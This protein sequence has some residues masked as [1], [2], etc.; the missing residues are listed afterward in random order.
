MN[1]QM[2]KFRQLPCR[3]NVAWQGDIIKMPSWITEDAPAPY[4]PVTALWADAVSGLVHN[5]DLLH[6]DK[7]T[8]DA[9]LQCL[10]DFACNKKTAG[11]RPGILEVRNE[12]LADYMRQRLSDFDIKVRVRTRLQWL[13]EAQASLY[14]FFKVPD[15]PSPFSVKGITLDMMR[16]FAEAGVEFWRAQPWQY[17]C[18]EDL[19]EIETPFVDSKT[20]FMTVMGQGGETFGLGF[21]ESRDQYDKI[22]TSVPGDDSLHFSAW[23]VLFDPIISI[24]VKDADIWMDH[25][26]PVADENGYPYAILFSAG[27]KLRRPGSDLLAF[28]EGLL[29]VLAQDREDQLDAGRWTAT[30]PTFQGEM[31]FTLALPDVLTYLEDP[32]AVQKG[33]NDKLFD[34]RLMEKSMAELHKIIKE[35][36]FDDIDEINAFL[37]NHMKSGKITLPEPQTP[38]EKAQDLVYRALQARGRIRVLLARKALEIYPDCA[39]AYVLL[40]ERTTDSLKAHDLYLEGMLAGERT[41]GP[42]T[43]SE[44]AGHFWGLLE[45]RPYMRARLGLAQTLENLDRMEEACEH[46]RELLRLNPNDNQGVREVFIPALL[47]LNTNETNNELEQLLNKYDEKH[48]AV[49][50]YTRALLSFRQKGDAPASR[51]HLKHAFKVNPHVAG[52]LLADEDEE[53]SDA[54]NGY[55]AGSPEEAAYCV[56]LLEDE[57]AATDGAMDWLEKY[58]PV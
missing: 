49:W 58:Y 17:F 19:I 43:F 1:F 14:Q 4:R 56:N 36:E 39:D 27:K 38:A 22:Q 41:L 9:L 15:I 2:E 12:Q 48:M 25:H 10:I 54:R 34:R 6:P 33:K 44:D 23:S 21:F 11:F 5:G 46:Y 47:H 28:F 40:A 16:S 20:R 24:P 8:P 13:D 53:Y 51:K 18:D 50:S 32:A 30:V 37:E 26:L 29:R 31:T 57:W 7:A 3:P 42:T 35:Q 55:T 52:L 45:T